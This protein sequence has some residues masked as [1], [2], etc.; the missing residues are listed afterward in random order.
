MQDITFFIRLSYLLATPALIYH[1]Q[2]AVS[3]TISKLSNQL[4][5]IFQPPKFV[6][7]VFRKDPKTNKNNTGCSKVND[8]SFGACLPWN[9]YVLLSW[10]IS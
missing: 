5:S 9:G 6:Q 7:K 8:I 3:K 10:N 4:I 1:L 2:N